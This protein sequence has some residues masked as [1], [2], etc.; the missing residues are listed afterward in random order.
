MIATQYQSNIQVIRT[1][2]RGEFINQDLKR[3]LNL[4]GVVHQTTCPYTPQ[5]NRVAE[6]KNRH[7]LEV[8]RASLFGA[9]MPTN[10]WGE[11]ITTT[12]YLINHIPSSSLQFQTPFDVLH[13]TVSATTILNLSPKVFGC[14]AF[15]HLHKGLRTKL[16]PQALRC[17]F[18]GYALHQKGYQCY[19]PHSRK[20]YVT[21]DVVFHENDMYYS[22]SSLQGE[23]RDEVQ[24]LHHPLDNLDF[25]KVITWKLVVNVKVMITLEKSIFIGRK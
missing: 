7:L 6:R 5:Q 19:H 15:M 21:F 4:H 9:H 25:K 22:E 11:A 3:Y 10:Y 23:N 12:A 13:H 14:V 17:V 18:V 8:V 16:E 2:N 1:D 24:T 20:L